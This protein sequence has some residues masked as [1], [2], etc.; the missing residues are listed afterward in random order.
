MALDA[1]WQAALAAVYLAGWAAIPVLDKFALRDHGEVYLAWSV[2]A[3]S[4]A[5]VAVY[6]ILFEEGNYV[7]AAGRAMASGYVLASAVCTCTVYA[8]Y[9]ILLDARGVLLIVMLQPAILIAQAVLAAIVL[10]EHVT[11]WN[12]GGIAVM[13][14]GMLLF[15]AEAL[16]RLRSSSSRVPTPDL[17]DT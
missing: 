15:N 12:A 9:Y 5:F 3:L 10:R 4:A 17:Q 8:V 6:G 2:F 11:A 7:R 13:L 14:L 1:A 16:L